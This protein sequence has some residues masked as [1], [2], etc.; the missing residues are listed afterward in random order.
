[1]EGKNT[2]FYEVGYH[3]VS[4]I[5]ED[6]V[7][8]EIAKLRQAIESRSGSV[9][10]EEWPKKTELAYTISRREGGK[11]AKY[12][13]SYFGW[14]RFTMKAESTHPQDL[15]QEEKVSRFFLTLE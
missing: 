9:V 10:A 2:E 13:S 6:K 4:T 11:R 7:G 12:D 3:L 5:S 15:H 14:I 8:P 1:M